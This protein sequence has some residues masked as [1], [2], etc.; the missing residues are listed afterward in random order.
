MSTIPSLIVSCWKWWSTDNTDGG[1]QQH[2][3]TVGSMEAMLRE[4]GDVL[5]GGTSR[6]IARMFFTGVAPVAFSDGQSSL[7]MVTDT[8]LHTHLH[9]TLKHTHSHTHSHTL[10]HNT[11]THTYIQH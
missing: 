6:S 9:T 10:T 8:H 7:N 5:K 11:Y 2:K 4:F 1:L 3:E